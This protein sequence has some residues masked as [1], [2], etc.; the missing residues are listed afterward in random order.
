MALVGV[1]IL[2]LIVVSVLIGPFMYGTDPQLLDIGQK[3]LGVSWSHP[4]WHR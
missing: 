4:V 3:N 1:S 2:F